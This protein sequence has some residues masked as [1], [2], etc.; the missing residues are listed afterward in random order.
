MDSFV[1]VAPTGQPLSAKT[2]A[3]AEKEMKH[4]ADHW[5]KQFRGDA[6]MKKDT[7]VTD[8]DIRNSNLVLWGDAQSNKVLGRIAAKLPAKWVVRKELRD[9]R[10]VEVTSVV[11]GDKEY[12]ADTHMP[13]L[14]YPNPLNPTKYV[15]L[16]SG[17]TFREYDQLNNARQV[18]KLPDYAVIDVTTPPNS[19]FPGKVVRAGFFGEK[20][21]LLADDGK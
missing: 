17:F 8:D 9:G 7:E 13:V 11:L 19:R 4:A 1:N 2:G 10:E 21:E 12:P 15:V 6:P 3:W 18:P 14:I 5:R 16:N 20:W